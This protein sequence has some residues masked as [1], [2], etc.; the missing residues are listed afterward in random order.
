MSH[1]KFLLFSPRLDNGQCPD[2]VLTPIVLAVLLLRSIYTFPTGNWQSEHRDTIILGCLF[3]F[4]SGLRVYTF[5]SVNPTETLRLRNW[6]QNFNL[7]SAPQDFFLASAVSSAEEFSASSPLAWQHCVKLSKP[8]E[9]WA[10]NVGAGKSLPRL[11]WNAV[12]DVQSCSHRQQEQLCCW[13]LV[14]SCL[15]VVV[16]RYP[17]LVNRWD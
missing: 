16:S 2:L 15:L 4:F 3:F 12:L 17:C 1:P 13:C 8:I 11:Q 9:L 7:Q 14:P 5:N 10:G 6:L